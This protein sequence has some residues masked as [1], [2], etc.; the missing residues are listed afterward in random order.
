MRGIGFAVILL[1]IALM[2]LVLSRRPP[3]DRAQERQSGAVVRNA[4]TLLDPTRYDI[5]SMVS[6]PLE[7]CADD[8]SPTDYIVVGPSAIFVIEAQKFGG[9]VYGRNQD[10]FWTHVLWGHK[11][12]IPSPAYK[13]ASRIKS[14]QQVFHTI[15][16]ESWVPLI[17]VLDRLERHLDS[18]ATETM[19]PVSCLPAAILRHGGPS[20]K[21]EQ[22][23]TVIRQLIQWKHRPPPIARHPA[24]RWEKLPEPS[25]A[26][27]GNCPL[28]GS[29]LTLAMAGQQPL[30]QCTR[31]PDC[32]FATTVLPISALRRPSP[33]PA[34]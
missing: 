13:N 33:S 15:P 31:Y 24:A 29:S 23:E 32:Q 5:F 7:Y 17:A 1:G 6:L 27:S 34:E 21:P 10:E 18:P 30:M 2:I 11:R 14:L 28:C 26:A 20:L 25:D 3:T 19:V 22:R 12:K 4:L 8:D 9:V 16:P